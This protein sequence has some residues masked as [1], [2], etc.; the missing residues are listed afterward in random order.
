MY[1]LLHLELV[2]KDGLKSIRKT[3]YTVETKIKT[4]DYNQY[5]VHQVGRMNDVGGTGVY[6]LLCEG[7]C[8]AAG[9]CIG[10]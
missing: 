10:E 3:A 8:K 9:C 1:D 7:E 6:T 2:I 5:N 4:M